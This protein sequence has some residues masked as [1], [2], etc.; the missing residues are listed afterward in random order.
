MYQ[1]GDLGIMI[2]QYK[3]MIKKYLEFLN[4]NKTDVKIEYATSSDDKRLDDLNKLAADF[5]GTDEDPSQISPSHESV[6][7]GF[8]IGA[9][10]TLALDKDNELVG[11]GFAFPTTQELMY[12]FL[13][14]KITES[15][16]FI[17][18]KNGDNGAVYFCSVFITP[19]YRTFNTARNLIIK[20]IE[21]L[22]NNDNIVFY[23]TFSKEGEVIGNYLRKYVSNKVISKNDV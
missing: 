8:E 2:Y 19:E 11:W 6:V 7:H 1:V 20:S 9:K 12:D 17:N 16:L 21:P 5:F 15:E 13:N 3:I 14:D 18:T 22:L 10:T 23:D 4:E